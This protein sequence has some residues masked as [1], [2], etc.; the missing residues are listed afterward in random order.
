ME[1][2]RLKLQIPLRWGDMDA[3]GHIN[4][5]EIVRILEEARVHAFGQ[6]TGTGLPGS[7]VSIPIFNDLPAGVQILVVE[8]R[9]KYLAPLN[10][11]NIPAR[12]DLWVSSLKGASITLAYAI[13]DPAD[14]TR[15]VI[16]ETVLAF[17]DSV[18]SRLLRVEPAHRERLSALL[19]ESNFN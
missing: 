6:P 2:N 19:G 1:Q 10:Y 3:Y 5:V 15:C 16:A 7:E 13:Y 8:H 18:A 14:G 4:N 9:I 11:R 12:V 17:F